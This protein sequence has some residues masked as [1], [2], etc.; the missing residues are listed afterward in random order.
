MAK[1][2]KKLDE[3]F[4]NTLKDI[5]FRGKEDTPDTAENGESCPK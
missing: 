1:E 4:H 5:I 2:P 3:L